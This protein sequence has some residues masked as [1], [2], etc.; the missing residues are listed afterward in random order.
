MCR[1]YGTNFGVRYAPQ[2]GVCFA[3]A[4]A[5]ASRHLPWAIL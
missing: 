5:T 2:G 3:F 1:T 4:I